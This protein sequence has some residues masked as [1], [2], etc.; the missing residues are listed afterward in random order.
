MRWVLGLV[1]WLA[2]AG[3]ANNDCGSGP[4]TTR[5]LVTGTGTEAVATSFVT[6]HFI[7]FDSQGFPFSKS[8]G[9]PPAEFNLSGTD[10]EFIFGRPGRA[11]AT[12]VLGMKVGGQRDATLPPDQ[13]FGSDYPSSCQP[14]RY[15]LELVAVD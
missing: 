15:T 8:Y 4:V 3:C 2:V 13:A 11:I 14:I 12:A 10:A 1:G 5:E 9:G 7:A 6:V